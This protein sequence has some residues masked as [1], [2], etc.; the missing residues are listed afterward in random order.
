MKNSFGARGVDPNSVRQ[1]TLRCKEQGLVF[2]AAEDK[3]RNKKVGGR[4]SSGPTVS[5]LRAACKLRGLVLDA[6]T[7]DCRPRATRPRASGPTQKEIRA[8]CKQEGL[9]FDRETK[10]C[11]PSKYGNRFGCD[12]GYTEGCWEYN[13]PPCVGC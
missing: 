13:G 3:C 4:K 9:V 8:M 5:E 12:D 7:K 2:D 11:R 10:R 6:A 1:K